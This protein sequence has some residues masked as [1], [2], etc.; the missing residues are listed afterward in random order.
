MRNIRKWLDRL[1]DQ[2]EAFGYH[3]EPTKSII[4]VSPDL[5]QQL[6]DIFGDL[7]IKVATSA[8]FLGGCIGEPDGVKSF[9][10]G[11]VETCVSSV[12]CLAAAARKYPQS[13]Y[14]ALNLS[15]SCE[16]SYLQG[17]VPGVEE[18]F[19]P[20]R[21]VI[22]EQFAPA[23]LGWEVLPQKHQLLTLPVKYGGLALADHVHSA[24]RAH[25]N[26]RNAADIDMRCKINK[27][28]QHS[29]QLHRIW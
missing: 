5:V 26:S 13:A 20:L 19:S 24:P 17:V 11:R 28:Q 10:K 16:W 18:E 1:L 25:Q 23:I 8:R 21:D 14:W 2:G 4:I 9:V 15:L 22:L 12:N 29:A 3:V 7:D 6:T 27:Q